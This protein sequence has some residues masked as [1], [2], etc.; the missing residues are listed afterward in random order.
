MGKYATPLVMAEAARQD[1]PPSDFEILRQME[2]AGISI[3]FEAHERVVLEL[4][5]VEIVIQRSDRAA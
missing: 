2:W 4:T 1:Y 3:R 5:E